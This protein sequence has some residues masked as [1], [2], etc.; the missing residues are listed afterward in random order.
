LNEIEG[1]IDDIRNRYTPR[2]E[3]I[4]ENIEDINLEIEQLQNEMNSLR[5]TFG[6]GYRGET[7]SEKRRNKEKYHNLEKRQER[8]ELKIEQLESKKKLITNR[9]NEEVK[10]IND[11]YDKLV[12]NS[13]EKYEFTPEE[14]DYKIQGKKLLWLSRVIGEV[15]TMSNTFSVTYDYKKI[16]KIG[17]CNSCKSN[18]IDVD[19]IHVCSICGNTFCSKH[20]LKCEKC[21]KEICKRDSWTCSICNKVYC[22]DEKKIKCNEC[23]DKFCEDCINKCSICDNNFCKKHLEKCSVCKKLVC[24]KDSK[25]CPVCKKVVCKNCLTKCKGCKKAVC[26]D[27]FVKCPNCGKTVCKDCVRYK[28]KFLVV[29]KQRCIFCIDEEDKVNRNAPT[30]FEKIKRKVRSK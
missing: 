30:L 6:F 15:N 5:G 27:D 24:K 9:M 11:R 13:I 10:R 12:N 2:I 20:I 21:N 26:K 14:Y 16:T 18:F 19:D 25:K 3:D 7:D 28:R 22:K 1:K 23:E 29:K 8:K 17:E 4:E